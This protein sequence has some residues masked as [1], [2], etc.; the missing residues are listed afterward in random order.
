[1]KNIVLVGMPGC[2]KSS[3]GVVL[4]KNL[5]MNFC[6]VDILIQEKEQRGLQ[7]IIDS[8]GVD[9]FLNI[10]EAVCLSIDFDNTVIA[11]GGSVILS[12]KAV[13]HLKEN[14]IMVYIR[15]PY[16]A[17]EQRIHNLESR[18][19]AMSKTETLF[20]VYSKRTVLYEKHADITVD[21]DGL[22]PMEC[23]QTLQDTIMKHHKK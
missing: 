12:E 22:S 13:M 17:I 6:D 11:T 16:E 18:G 19:I 4:S 3:L 14:G 23:I 21:I 5:K 8:E 10:E 9:R 20:D 1:M 2:G 15:L 7:E